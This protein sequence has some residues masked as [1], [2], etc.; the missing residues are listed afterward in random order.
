M[1][2]LGFE[3]PSKS[4]A[5]DGPC[6]SFRTLKWMGSS[7]SANCLSGIVSCVFE[8]FGIFAIRENYLV[9]YVQKLQ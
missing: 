6:T 8:R 9:N 4:D 7:P 2:A 1:Y 5:K 3:H